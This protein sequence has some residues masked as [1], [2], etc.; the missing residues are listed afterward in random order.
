MKYE[1]IKMKDFM[2]DATN[3]YIKFI[4]HDDARGFAVTSVLDAMGLDKHY[5]MIVVNK[6]VDNRLEFELY[7]RS[8]IWKAIFNGLKQDCD[9]PETNIYYSFERKWFIHDPVP[10]EKVVNARA[11]FA[12][13]IYLKEK[14]KL[15]EEEVQEW[16]R[17]LGMIYHYP[18]CLV[19]KEM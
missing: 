8:R 4:E 13:T 16:D 5:E 11:I 7:D 9:N 14:K 18:L 19:I 2:R 10:G 17:V 15:T 1:I 3:G 12:T 6:T